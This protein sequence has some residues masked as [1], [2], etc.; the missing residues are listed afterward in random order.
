MPLSWFSWLIIW[1]WIILK[2]LV[3]ILISNLKC[4]FSEISILYVKLFYCK[5]IA[6]LSKCCEVFGS[7]YQRFSNLRFFFSSQTLCPQSDWKGQ[8]RS[9][10]F[11]ILL[12][13]DLIIVSCTILVH[14]K[15]VWTFQRFRITI[16]NFMQENHCLHFWRISFWSISSMQVFTNALHCIT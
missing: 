16:K 6:K 2:F 11:Y 4:F 1:N 3:F 9:I 15:W 12:L 10:R 8:S 14:L 13:S 5:I 7:L